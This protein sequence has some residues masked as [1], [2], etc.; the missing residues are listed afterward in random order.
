M[1]YRGKKNQTGKILLLIII[2]ALTTLGLFY[3]TEY[4]RKLKTVQTQTKV[5]KQKPV[6]ELT[7]VKSRLLFTG[8][9]FW[10]R[11]I[12]DWSMASDLKYKYP[13]SRLDEFKRDQYDSWITGIECP[14]SDKVNMTSAEQEA[15]LQFNCRPE[16]L[17]E[18]AKFFDVTTLANNHTDNQGIGGFEETKQHLK[19]HKIQYFGHYD[20]RATDQ[21]CKVI[22]IRAKYQQSDNSIK[23]G[24]LP[25]AMCGYHGVF[26]IPPQESIDVIK[27]YQPYL[28]VFALP[29]MG[30][31]YKPGPDDI[32]RSTYHRIIDAGAD[33]ILADHPHWVQSTESYKGKLIVYSM[34]NFM[35]DQQFNTE[36]TRSAAIKVNLLAN[37]QDL[38]KWFELGQKCYDVNGD[39]LDQIK[40]ANLNK[41]DYK[42]EFGVV[43]TNDQN[44]ITKP[45][46]A[47]QTEQILERLKWQQTVKQLKPPYYALD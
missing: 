19:D 18:A 34:G 16:F 36:V 33:A 2:I 6:V 24:F 22:A 3:S 42:F 23:T 29:H 20:P 31:E 25:V 10:G 7:S 40:Q 9:I 8:N 17:S 12:R 21:I 28:P 4:E 47:A 26:R 38:D 43:G 5:S 41:I 44:K 32:K 14:I 37:N 27:Q 30:A 15:Q 11:Y 39:C 13:F 45:A 35:F 1:K 46:T